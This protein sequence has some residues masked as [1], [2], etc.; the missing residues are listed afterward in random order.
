MT[1]QLQVLWLNKTLSYLRAFLLL[2]RISA[3]YHWIWIKHLS[4]QDSGK[5][6]H[7]FKGWSLS[8]KILYISAVVS[9]FSF[10]WLG[11]RSL[12]KPQDAWAGLSFSS[13]LCSAL[14]PWP[15]FLPACLQ[16]GSTCTA[17]GLPQLSCTSSRT[18]PQPGPLHAMV[19][20]IRN[21]SWQG[22]SYVI[23]ILINNN[24]GSL[25]IHRCLLQGLA[26]HGLHVFHFIDT[27]QPP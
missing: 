11:D 4:K 13:V 10:H 26:F 17:L 5:L 27:P 22:D 20:R 8:I 6:G 12:A 18:K 16:V 21:K 25:N 1:N 9:V 19:H 3:S 14:P 15:R 7:L 23:I 24:H 2:C